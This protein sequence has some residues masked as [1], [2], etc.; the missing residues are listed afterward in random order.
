[1]SSKVVYLSACLTPCLIRWLPEFVKKS[2]VMLIGTGKD[3]MK[4]DAMRSSSFTVTSYD[5]A[6][7]RHQYLKEVGFK[8]RLFFQF[9]SPFRA[10]PQCIL[11]RVRETIL[12]FCYIMIIML[13]VSIQRVVFCAYGD[14]V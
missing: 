7:K 6:A 13:V 9:S 2:D 10:L 8:V 11:P 14:K 1:M 4:V 3:I 5:L 12:R